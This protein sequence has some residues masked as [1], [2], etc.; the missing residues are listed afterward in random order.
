[1]SDAL[2]VH[3]SFYEAIEAGDVDLLRALWIDRPDTTCAH[4][5]TA[6]VVGTATIVRSWTML[7]AATDYLQFFLT[8]VQVAYLAD[9]AVAVVSC[10]ENIL[11]GQGLESA[12]NF[13]GGRVTSTSILVHGGGTW[14]FHSRHASP[15]IEFVSDDEEQ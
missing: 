14:R 1:M 8:D 4:P 11:S 10:T 13:A 6:P 3:R 9:G 12:E 15:V 2:A 5:G 7:M